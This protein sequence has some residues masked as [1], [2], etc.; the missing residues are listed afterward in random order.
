MKKIFINK[1]NCDIAIRLESKIHELETL[2]SEMNN[3]E[4]HDLG[5]AVMDD[6]NLTLYSVGLAKYKKAFRE[7]QVMR[8]WIR[9]M[10]K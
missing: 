1:C 8:R 5:G 3:N 9:R 6:G 4:P 2:I 7:N 10:R